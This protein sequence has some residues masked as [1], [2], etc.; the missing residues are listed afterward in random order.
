[1]QV[2]FTFIVTSH[3]FIDAAITS[4]ASPAPPNLDK[5]IQH[6]C[7]TRFL[8]FISKEQPLSR[9]AISPLRTIFGSEVDSTG[10]LALEQ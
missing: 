2:T 9:L 7:L 5:K 6:L 4:F 10:L 3:C 1:M 8:L